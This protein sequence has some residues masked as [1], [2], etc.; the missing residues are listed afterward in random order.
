M[1]FCS[2]VIPLNRPAL[3]ALAELRHRAELLGSSEPAHYVFPAFENGQ[4][5]VN[6]PMKSWRSAWRSL[7]LAAGLKGPA[8]P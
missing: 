7:T 1:P 2:R 5:D 3:L 8:L 4:I 6:K